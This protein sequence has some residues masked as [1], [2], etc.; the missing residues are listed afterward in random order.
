MC[1]DEVKV[2]EDIRVIH[3]ELEKADTWIFAA[4]EILRPENEEFEPD[5][6]DIGNIETVLA[7]AIQSLKTAISYC[8]I[9]RGGKQETPSPKY[10]PKSKKQPSLDELKR[11]IVDQTFSG[12]LRSDFN[13]TKLREAQEALT[14]L[15]KK[16]SILRSTIGLERPKNKITPGELKIYKDK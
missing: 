10:E 3:D 16:L 1:C 12:F 4:Q 5:L 15:E 6:K 14:D 13:Q 7:F 9:Y 8:E 2:S 11:D